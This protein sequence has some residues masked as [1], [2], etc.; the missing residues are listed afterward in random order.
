MIY[1]EKEGTN[2]TIKN[3]HKACERINAKEE[4]RK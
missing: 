1:G 2:G 3:N 4:T